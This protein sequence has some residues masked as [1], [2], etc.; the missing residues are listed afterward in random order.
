MTKLSLL[1]AQAQPA[2]PS[3]GSM[4]MQ[5]LPLVLMFAAM[6]FLLIAPQRKKQKEHEKM[7]G[8]LKAG[9]EIITTGGIY[10]TITS[11]KEDRFIVRVG[12]N[13]QKLE[14]G[15]GF[16]HALVKKTDA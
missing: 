12:D 3:G 2:A 13:T 7:L 6:Y 16:V 15:K 9:D 1:L 4:L 14:I 10:G 8:G 11:V 5:M